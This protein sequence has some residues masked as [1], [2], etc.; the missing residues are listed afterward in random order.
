MEPH[1]R[2]GFTLR[3]VHTRKEEPVS[4]QQ[5]PVGSNLTE[6]APHRVCARSGGRATGYPRI[7]YSPFRRA[8]Q[9]TQNVDLTSEVVFPLASAIF[10]A[11][12][13]VNMFTS[14]IIANFVSEMFTRT[15]PSATLK[16]V[17]IL[18]GRGLTTGRGGV[19]TDTDREPKAEPKP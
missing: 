11:I 9:R 16:N 12:C 1:Q 10:R 4:G 2:F 19:C 6:G 8:S 18:Q 13:R 5:R 14:R 7:S 15:M 17:Q 3:F